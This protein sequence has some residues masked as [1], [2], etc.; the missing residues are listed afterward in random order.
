MTYMFYSDLIL[1]G[2]IR[3]EIK[4]LSFLRYKGLLHV[5]NL[6]R[7][8]SCAREHKVTLQGLM[9]D[10]LYFSLEERLIRLFDKSLSSKEQLG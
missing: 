4:C 8:D 2:G 9:Y 7:K 6:R 3:S 10:S 5:G 1:F